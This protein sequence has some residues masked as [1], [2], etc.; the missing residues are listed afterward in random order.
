MRADEA[1]ALGALAG[2]AIAGTADIV[3]D[4]HEAVVARTPARGGPVGAAH[5]A[6]ARPVYA[7]VRGL[8]RA[9]AGAAGAGVSRTRPAAAAA[10]ADSGGGALALGALAGLKGDRLERELAAL[11]PAMG[12]RVAGR[13]VAPERAALAAAFPGAGPRLAV[14]VHGWCET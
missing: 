2:A 6:I 8:G 4:V 5:G 12:V 14:F 9:I 11:A 10:L 1:R 7:T 13:T 3:A